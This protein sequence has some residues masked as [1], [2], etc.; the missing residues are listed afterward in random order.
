MKFLSGFNIKNLHEKQQENFSLL[1]PSFRVKL[2]R[3]RNS[4]W[5]VAWVKQLRAVALCTLQDL[6]VAEGAA[7]LRRGSFLT[8]L[9]GE[10]GPRVLL[11]FRLILL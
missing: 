5:D 4:V 7:V 3:V 2:F 8:S 1:K 11:S 10:P 9:H 6:A